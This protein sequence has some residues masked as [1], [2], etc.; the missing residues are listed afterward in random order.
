M[1]CEFIRG[2][3][4]VLP[5]NVTNAGIV[6]LLGA[7]F[8]TADYAST[9]LYMGL[10]DGV[11]SP[12]MTIS[13]ITEP[14]SGTNGY[15]RVNLPRAST[16]WTQG[17]LSGEPYV[18]CEPVVFAPTSTGFDQPITRAFISSNLTGEAVLMLSSPLAIPVTLTPSTPLIERT[19]K[20]RL[21]LR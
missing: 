18:E 13:S 20:Y 2:D 9:A 10:C 3:G 14:T 11:Y 17:N 15:A 21:Y 5:N 12:A 6:R 7:L 8:Q 16:T 1:R 4:L 19:F